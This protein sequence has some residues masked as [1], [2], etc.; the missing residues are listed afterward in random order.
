MTIGECIVA[1]IV[2]LFSVVSFLLI[3]LDMFGAFKSPI[4][5]PRD[6]SQLRKVWIEIEPDRYLKEEK[7][8]KSGSHQIGVKTHVY[9][10]EQSREV[11]GTVSVQENGLWNG[12]MW[13]GYQKVFL[14]L[15]DAKK[16]V[17]NYQVRIVK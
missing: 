10:Y 6:G 1:S 13:N 15:E 3:I 4:P 2:L 16:W 11:R 7:Y 12:Q 9:I 8:I 5:T 14:N 17:E